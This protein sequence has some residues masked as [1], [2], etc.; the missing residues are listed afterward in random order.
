MIDESIE[1]IKRR[2]GISALEEDEKRAIAEMVSRVVTYEEALKHTKSEYKK[3]GKL[4]TSEIVVTYK[5]RKVATYHDN[6]DQEIRL[7]GASRQLKPF[8]KKTGGG[9]DT[10]GAA[11]RSVAD[12]ASK[13]SG[14]KGW[15][16]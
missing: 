16:G 15:Q 12:A 11:Q 10:L 14:G 9:V 3:H 13:A 7:T 8:L 4:N 2:G 5:G 6:W 1:Y